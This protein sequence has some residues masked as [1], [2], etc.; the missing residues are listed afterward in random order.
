MATFILPDGTSFEA[1]AEMRG[2]VEWTAAGRKTVRAKSDLL[3]D[4]LWE[5][6]AAE[7]LCLSLRTLR[8][9]AQAKA[10]GRKVGRAWLFTKAEVI[11][12]GERNSTCSQFLGGQNRL[13]GTLGA[14]ATD[15]VFSRLQRCETKALLADL[16]TNL[17]SNSPSQP[18]GNVTPL[19]SGK[20]PRST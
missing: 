1:A 6:E 12:L 7:Q 11:E 19:H 4:M 9:R 13:S 5:E 2:R 17:K 18:G 10:I 3:R 15:A 16:R 8:R 14:D 20:P